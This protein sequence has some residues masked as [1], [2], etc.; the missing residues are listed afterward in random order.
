ME[1][2]LLKISGIQHFSFCRRQWALI[3]IEDCWDENQLTAEGRVMH[4]RVHDTGIITKRNGVITLRGVAVRSDRMKITG[5]CDAVELIS[6]DTGIK[7]HDR[8][9]KW[10]IHPIEYKHGKSKAEDCDRLQLAAQCMCLE[11]MLCC[12]IEQGSL[13]YGMTR[14]RESVAIDESLRMQLEK[15]TAEM[16]DYFQRKYT[17]K[18]RATKSCQS[19]SLKNLCLPKLMTAN[20]V[21]DYVQKHLYEEAE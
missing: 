18:V 1:E 17:P 21:S 16:W 11:E 2:E 7:L 12:K 20:K 19:C 4:E 14:R 9:G 10:R 6:D 15:M 3:H 13:Y 5:T 8:E